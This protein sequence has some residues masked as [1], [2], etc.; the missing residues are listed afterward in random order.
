MGREKI[1]TTKNE[2]SFIMALRMLGIQI[3]ITDA[4]T[5]YRLALY[6]NEKEGEISIAEVAVIQSET[7]K[8]ESYEK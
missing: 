4:K 3:R 1:K 2:L 8:E 5:V 6:T 7:E